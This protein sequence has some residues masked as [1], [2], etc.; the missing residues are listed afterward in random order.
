MKWNYLDLFAGCGGFHKGLLEAGFEFEWTGFSEIDKHAK[1]IYQRHF[2]NSEDLG[3]VRTIDLDRLPRINLITFGFPCQDLSVA[4]K[5]GG[6]KAS[7]SSLFFE[8]MRIVRATK[9]R[10]FIFENVKG[11]FFQ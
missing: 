3:D 11:L 10:Y 9:S 8:A 4:G 6:L 1:K 7:R 5:R 2:P